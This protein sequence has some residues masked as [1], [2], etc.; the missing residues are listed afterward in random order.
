MDQQVL[1]SLLASIEKREA[2]AL[3]TVTEGDGAFSVNVGRHCLVWPDAQ[4]A[5]VGELGLGDLELSALDDVRRVIRGKEHRTLD[6]AT[7]AGNISLFV[8]VQRRPPHLII[9]G[10]G[11]IAV[12]LAATAKICD[13]QVTVL[14]DR[15]LY[16]TPTRFPT[17]DR[18]IAGPFVA[19]LRNLR[20]GRPTF[21][22]DTYIVLVTRGHQYDIASLLEVLDDPLAYIG[23]IGSKRRIRAVYQLLE[24]EQ[25]IPAHKFTRIHA[26]I[27]LPINAHTP[28]EIAVCI[29]AEIISVLRG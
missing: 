4:R 27:G 19:E 17:A 28:A 6:F 16:A 1:E 25:G 10:A 14:D 11:H 18:V 7:D 21:D 2:V 12:P 8:E 9:V 13:F 5:T 26:P 22:D 3:V 23:M 29:M 15:T 24:Q 20:Q